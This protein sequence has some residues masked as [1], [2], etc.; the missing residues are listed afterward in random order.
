MLY[1][2]CN[3]VVSRAP[4]GARGLKLTWPPSDLESLGRAP[5]GARGLKQDWLSI[6]SITLCRAPRGARGLKQTTPTKY[7]FTTK[8]RVGIECNDFQHPAHGQTHTAQ[9]GLP[10]YQSWIHSDSVQSLHIPPLLLLVSTVNCR[11]SKAVGLKSAW[12]HTPSSLAIEFRLCGIYP[13]SIREA[14]FAPF[15]L[16]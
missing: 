5:R 14:W 6:P 8:S 4:R 10:I 12:S 11:R 15:G 3:L 9:A 1:W 16:E 13:R 7:T 2:L